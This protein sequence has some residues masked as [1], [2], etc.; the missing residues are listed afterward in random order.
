VKRNHVGWFAAGTLWAILAAAVFPLICLGGTEGDIERGGWI[1]SGTRRAF[2]PSGTPRQPA[3]PVTATA[4]G[5]ARIVRALFHSGDTLWIGTEGGLFAYDAAGDSLSAISGPAFRAVTAIAI[6]DA[7]RLWVGGDEG[8]SVRTGGVWLHY[9]SNRNSFFERVTDLALGDGRIWVGTY[10]HGCAAVGDDSM[11]IYTRADS[12][13]DDR[14]RCIFEETSYSIWFGTASGLCASD[15]MAWTSMRYGHKIPIGAITDL[16][17]DELGDL[18]L[19]V[20]RQGIVRYSLGRV[21]RYGPHDGAPGVEVYAFSLD[22]TGR[23]WAAGET[24]LSVFDR[25]GWVPYRQPGMP[26]DGYR[27]RSITHDVEGTIFAGT[28]V[29]TVL[30]LSRD[31]VRAIYLPQGFPDARVCRILPQSEALWFLTGSGIYELR[32]SMNEIEPPA[33]WCAGAMTDLVERSP[34]EIWI[35]TRFGILHRVDGSWEIFD[36]RQGLPTEYFTRASKDSRGHLWFGTFETGVLEFT[37][38]GWVHHTIEHG[39]PDDRIEDLL[40]DADDRPWVVTA[41]DRI[42]RFDGGTWHEVILPK[43][44]FGSEAESIAGD[45]LLQFDP[46]ITFLTEG[47]GEHV[48]TGDRGRTVLGLDGRGGCIVAGGDGIFIRDGESWRVM[49]LPDAGAEIVPTAVLATRRGSLWLGT[50]DTGVYLLHSG[51]WHH[52]NTLSGMAD[53]R[54]LTVAE[55]MRGDVWVG[56][57]F[58]GIVRFSQKQ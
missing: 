48:R 31:S 55:D 16:C 3:A 45:S 18:F 10:G 8:L 54:V 25:T 58:G 11:T 40:V 32:G 7:G 50:F 12:L 47:R 14:V 37:G 42:A 21:Q 57:Q 15:T 13:L 49:D 52:F 53:N 17:F 19:A 23:V 20:E 30:L 2:L 46:A 38:S 26:L 34:G 24:G 51:T 6:D 9:L 41:G 29:G 22:P 28:D 35:T 39:L 33:A 44:D 27:F 5:P 4:F 1:A 36:R 43:R 56:T